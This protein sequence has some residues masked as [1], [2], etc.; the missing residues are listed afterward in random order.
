[1]NALKNRLLTAMTLAP[2]TVTLLGDEYQIKRLSAARLAKHDKSITE[3]RTSQDGD[4]LAK[5]HAQLIL[6]S[7]IDGDGTASDTTKAVELMEVHD[8]LSLVSAAQTVIRAN[9]GMDGA[10]E[11]AKN[12]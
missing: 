7:I 5:A 4:L 3:A 10:L 8:N 11:E 6:D 9:F 12:A 1:M 2:I